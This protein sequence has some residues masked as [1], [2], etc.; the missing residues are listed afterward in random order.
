MEGGGREVGGRGGFI[1]AKSAIV[2]I[3]SNETN[4][5]YFSLREINQFGLIEVNHSSLIG[6]NRV[7]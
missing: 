1:F 2:F 4:H 6:I 5:G 3:V 7:R